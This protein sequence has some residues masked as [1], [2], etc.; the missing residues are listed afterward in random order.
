MWGVAQEVEAGEIAPGGNFAK[1]RLGF[2]E[3]VM[4]RGLVQE[5]GAGSLQ[6]RQPVCHLIVWKKVFLEM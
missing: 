4:G 5:S 3:P 1:P 2:V 6:L